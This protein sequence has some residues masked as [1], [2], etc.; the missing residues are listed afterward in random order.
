MITS[1]F[2]ALRNGDVQMSDTVKIIVP[3]DGISYDY[4]FVAN[5]R[6]KNDICVQMV[7]TRED[8]ATITYP[9]E[10]FS[11]PYFVE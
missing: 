7:V 11:Y 3:A 8:E 5:K 6:G 1:K 4:E 2:D 10:S 9:V